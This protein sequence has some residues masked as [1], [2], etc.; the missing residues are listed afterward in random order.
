MLKPCDVASNTLRVIHNQLHKNETR[1]DFAVCV[2]GLNFPQDDLSVRFLSLFV[3]H[4]RKTLKNTNIVD[5]GQQNTN[6]R[7]SPIQI[8]RI[9]LAP[10][11]ALVVIMV[12]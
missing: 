6:L 11:G 1:K 5:V 3:V 12:Y 9:L 8:D 7:C 10:S 2:K 4:Q